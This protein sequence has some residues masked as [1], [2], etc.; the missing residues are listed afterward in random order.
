MA[1]TGGVD[2]EAS[3]G[4]ASWSPVPAA[5]GPASPGP[6]LR[7]PFELGAW[8]TEAKVPAASPRGQG[9]EL[10][11]ADATQQEAAAKSL[12]PRRRAEQL[13]AT[14]DGEP[15]AE[16][17]RIVLRTK[18]GLQVE[19]AERPRGK[20][21]LKRRR[22]P[23]EENGLR[24]QLKKLKEV[25]HDHAP[26]FSIDIATP[27]GE[28]VSFWR[29]V[30]AGQD[31]TVKV[32][33]LDALPAAEASACKLVATLKEHS[34]QVNCAR[35]APCT[36]RIASCDANGGLFVWALGAGK[37]PGLGSCEGPEPWH[38]K[39]I[40]SGHEKQ[41][42]DLAWNLSNTRL[43][44]L[45]SCSD[46]GTVRLWNSARGHVVVVL[47]APQPGGLVKGVA[48]DPLG[49]F[50]AAMWDAPGMENAPYPLLWE[51]PDDTGLTER[52]AESE[53]WRDVA[54]DQE[55]WRKPLPLAD[56]VY[57]R[58]PSWDPLGQSVCFPF[59]ERMR[60]KNKSPAYFA[61]LYRRGAWT[62][63][64]RYT[65]LDERVSALRFC[66]V[67]FGPPSSMDHASLVLALV[68]KDGRLLLWHSAQPVPIGVHSGHVDENCV[69]TDL[70]W[71]PDGSFLAFASNDGAVSCMEIA[72]AGQQIQR[73][74]P[75]EMRLW[76]SR[77]SIEVTQPI[78]D[79]PYDRHTLR[80]AEEQ[81]E[82]SKKRPHEAEPKLK[83]LPSGLQPAAKESSQKKLR[84][85]GLSRWEEDAAQKAAEASGK[86]VD[87]ESLARR[88]DRWEDPQSHQLPSAAKATRCEAAGWELIVEPV[89]T[90]A[91]NLMSRVSVQQRSAARAWVAKW[92]AL[93][94]GAVRVACLTS[95]SAAFVVEDSVRAELW[96][97]DVVSGQP[98]LPP[99]LLSDRPVSATLTEN[100]AVL[101]LLDSAGRLTALELLGDCGPSL[102]QEATLPS[103]CNGSLAE[104][105][106]LSYG[107]QGEGTLF[108]RWTDAVV[109]VFSPALMTW[110][111]LDSWRYTLSPMQCRLPLLCDPDA[112]PFRRRLDSWRMAKLPM[113]RFSTKH[114][115]DR[116][117]HREWLAHLQHDFQTMLELGSTLDIASSA[118]TL[119]AY[120]QDSEVHVSPREFLEAALLR[121][122][123]RSG[124][125]EPVLEEAEVRLRMFHSE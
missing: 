86:V 41:I 35:W 5:R 112:S 108:T 91:G 66:P 95:T 53:L 72:W 73:W 110:V 87:V 18:K 88:L 125:L 106:W 116:V 6:T 121:Y 7:G 17:R 15:K 68:S 76:R 104:M 111:A 61:A 19:E 43:Y 92:R 39:S 75:A 1:Q 51:C 119:L 9:G 42:C 62:D 10:Q 26:I 34:S 2:S 14:S 29:L 47:A 80:V 54:L 109:L 52:S 124:L 50:L 58:R 101:V 13:R 98:I 45:A 78:W 27:Q 123:S 16:R 25:T 89:Q 8:N 46:D 44:D 56:L 36:K 117:M 93:V 33:Q 67:A 113:C 122:P 74:S 38:R 120:L 100:G 30:S 11:L 22:R 69:I 114:E 28:E 115:A 81:A 4:R 40:L 83:R 105:G 85:A 60:G 82:A 37:S 118:A 84:L 64:H 107:E 97:H 94:D 24:I 96:V 55:L 23:G 65:G 20:H 63:P 32:W 59:G 21:L 12:T 48:F 3:A 79:L 70:A 71:A 99:L 90:E 102:L 103:C 57:A 77:A 49:Q 31:G